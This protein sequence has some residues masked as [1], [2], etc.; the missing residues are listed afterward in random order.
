M[1]NT[2]LHSGMWVFFNR[3]CCRVA[4]CEEVA[5]NM[6]DSQVSVCAEVLQ[7]DAGSGCRDAKPN[8][9]ELALLKQALGLP[10]SRPLANHHKAQ[11]SKFRYYLSTQPGTILPF[12][13]AV[14]WSSTQVCT[15]TLLASP[16]EHPLLSKDTA[17][18]FSF[19]DPNC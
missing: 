10:P 4:C 9:A 13:K 5:V 7:P 3:G 12:L 11:L 17:P 19:T 8:K 16:T 1:L 18:V 14:E 6:L 2:W 15:C